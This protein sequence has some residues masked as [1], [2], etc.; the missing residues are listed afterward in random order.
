VN[1]A[2]M[3]EPNDD[4]TR[5]RI[6]SLIFLDINDLKLEYDFNSIN[7]FLKALNE[8]EII[9]ISL[10]KFSTAIISIGGMSSLPMFEDMSRFFSTILASTIPNSQF[11]YFWARVNQ[12]LYNQLVE[13]ALRELKRSI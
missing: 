1:T 4:R 11:S 6:A 9:P 12:N 10:I 13:I 8:N 2:M 3:G 5:K 7:E